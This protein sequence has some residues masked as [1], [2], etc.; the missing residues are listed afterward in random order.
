[1]LT[2]YSFPLAPF[3]ELR[4]EVSRLFDDFGTTGRRAPFGGNAFPAL[5]VWDDGDALFV[6]AEL[7]GV[8]QD[9]L[10]IYAVG[11]ELTIKG[12]RVSPRDE[13]RTFHRQERGMGE[14]V[15]VVTLP[16]DVNS[17]AVE[18]TLERGVLSLRLPKAESAKRRKITVKTK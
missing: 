16:V 9:D 12:R 11:N 4:R 1:M 5:N 17:E 2:R 8:A 14:F 10:E 15:R 6:E 18:A 7:P 13:K 3:Q